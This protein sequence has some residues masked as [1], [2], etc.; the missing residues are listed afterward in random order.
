MLSFTGKNIA[1]KLFGKMLYIKC[2]SVAIKNIKIEFKIINFFVFILNNM[3]KKIKN[4]KK[5]YKKKENKNKNCI[6]IIGS[7]I[8]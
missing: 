8:L 7:M 2:E 4:I 5:L 3:A 1:V 6:L